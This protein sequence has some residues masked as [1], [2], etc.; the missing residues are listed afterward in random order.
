MILLV[1]LSRAKRVLSEAKEPLLI[2]C[3]K[4]LLFMHIPKAGPSSY[5][6]LGMTS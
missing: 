2:F 5:A 4:D 1:I 6:L 3:A